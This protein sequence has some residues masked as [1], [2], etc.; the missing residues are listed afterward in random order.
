MKLAL[1]LLF[2]GIFVYMTA[3]TIR[4]GMA[5]SLWDAWADYAAN[6]WAVATLYDAYFGFLT[7]YVW[8]WFKERRVWLRGLWFVLIM[9]LGNIAMSMYVLIQLHRLKADEPAEAVLWTRTV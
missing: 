1:K 8:V 6:P 9:C 7:F 4:A 2:A 5:I 3:V